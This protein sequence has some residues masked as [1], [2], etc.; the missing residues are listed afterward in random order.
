M[1]ILNRIL[2]L[3]LTAALWGCSSDP[4]PAQTPAATA[5]AD[6]TPA[7]TAAPA[8]AT[9]ST[10]PTPE[11]TVN[12]TS[13]EGISGVQKLIDDQVSQGILTPKMSE[14]D[15]KKIK[16]WGGAAGVRRLNVV[17]THS[18]EHKEE[19]TYWC[20]EGKVISFGGNGKDGD[21][22]YYY[23]AGVSPDGTLQGPPFKKVGG[24]SAEFSEKEVRERHAAGE[25][26]LKDAS[27]EG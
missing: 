11:V 8:D 17:V 26:T 22:S 4:K 14:K 23:W 1:K 21:V 9:P 13:E 27:A 10:S 2:I 7:A 5:T 12:L 16:A 24:K 15:N 18:P 19:I 3:V 25:A 6:A 20:Y